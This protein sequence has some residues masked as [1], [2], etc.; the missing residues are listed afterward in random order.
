VTPAQGLSPEM[1]E[2]CFQA[3]LLLVKPDPDGASVAVLIRPALAILGQFQNGFFY[4]F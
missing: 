3:K 4:S 1:E 2:S